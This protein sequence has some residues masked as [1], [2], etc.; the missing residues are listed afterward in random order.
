MPSEYCETIS[1]VPETCFIYNQYKDSVEYAAG[2]VKSWI[3][4][5]EK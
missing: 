2:K 5:W 3:E 4:E 1:L